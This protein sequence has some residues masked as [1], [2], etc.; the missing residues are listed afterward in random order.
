MDY[1]L[2]VGIHDV[3]AATEEDLN[4]SVDSE[5]N[6]G[7]V[8]QED[9]EDSADSCAAAATPPDSPV[10]L[11]IIHPFSGEPDPELEQFAIKSAP[12]K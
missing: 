1:S 4:T 12:S 9:E 10:G 11:G 6:G 3:E 5:A 2:L 8:S 7:A